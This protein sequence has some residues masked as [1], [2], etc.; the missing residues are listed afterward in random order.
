M[1]TLSELEKII[2]TQSINTVFQP[3]VSLST[4]DIIGYEAL[5]RGPEDSPLY[6]PEKLFEA[7]EI[8][9][10]TWELELACRIKAIERSKN[11]P[12]GKLLFLNV[13]PKIIKDK[14][15]KKGLTK[16][17]LLENNISPETIIF[18]I[19]EKTA[20]LDYKNFT[21]ILNNYTNQGY[22]IAIDDTG[23]GYSGLKTISE[24]KPNYIKLDIDLIRNIDSDSFKQSLIKAFVSFAKSTKIS[25][26]VEGIE[27]KEE[28]KAL[29]DLGV[30]AG[31][32]FFLKKPS[33]NF[34]EI[35][36]D[37][38]NLIAKYNELKTNYIYA[39]INR[40]GDI[41]QKYT[42]FKSE[43]LSS[44][45]KN[46]FSTHKVNGACIVKNDIPVGLV[47]KHTLDSMLATQ[48]GIVI[49]S[50][51]PVSLIMDTNALIVDY[52]TD[53][54][55]A[56]KL[57]MERSDDKIYDYV[58]VTKE[59]KYYGIVTIK[60]LLEFTIAIEKECAKEMNPLTGLPGNAV[61]ERTIGKTLISNSDYGI[62]YFDLDNF[63][64]YNDTYGFENGDKILLF[65][66]NLIKD[67]IDSLFPINSFTGHIG[68][69]DFVCVIETSYNN[70]ENLSKLIISK[71]DEKVINFFNEVD[72]KNKYIIAFD[73][74]GNK[75]IFNLTSISIAGVYG[76]IK[77]LGT[78]SN[79][80]LYV[81]KIKKK[82]K[83]IKKSS[84]I[85]EK[86][87]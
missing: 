43:V 67:T 30:D 7:A 44:T 23:S 87:K 6:M 73:R 47:M 79:L 78:T 61:I 22:K 55:K 53:V 10:R 54:N 41:A 25:L 24:T 21:S 27:T 16:E 32:G 4:G 85:I 72:K 42:C 2:K 15:F 59:G 71:F 37:V 17:F 66:A 28:L 14:N 35:P 82:N 19:T 86:L 36:F 65:T 63:K 52:N 70:C 68:G 18:E 34:L 77:K 49:F 31:Q 33:N 69:D 46:Y 8:Y 84:F 83:L 74:K 50:K 80:A 45:I 20:I 64:V 5:S 29:I 1:S 12:N 60:K 13:D 62:L 9:K 57:A 26:I 56:A 76:N 51:R 58:I 40:I 38:K 75:D 48:Y 39:S 81:S 11:M 3:I